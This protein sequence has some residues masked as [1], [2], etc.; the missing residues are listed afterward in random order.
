MRVGVGGSEQVV[1]VA[2]ERCL[3]VGINVDVIPGGGLQDIVAQNDRLTIALDANRVAAGLVDGVVD[4]LEAA[5]GRL[6]QEALGDIGVDQVGG[7]QCALAEEL[8]GVPA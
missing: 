3:A 8:F 5:G 1:V 2:A 7:D 6:D 4:R